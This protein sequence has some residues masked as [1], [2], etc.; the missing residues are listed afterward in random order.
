MESVAD[1]N[2]VGCPAQSDFFSLKKKSIFNDKYDVIKKVW[3]EKQMNTLFDLL[4]WYSLLDVRPF[5]EAVLIYLDLY[6]R[7][8]LDI[9]KMAISLPGISIHWAFDTMNKHETKFHLF[10]PKDADMAEIMR[11]NSNGEISQVFNHCQIKN[12]SCILGNLLIKVESFQDANALY[13]SATA[14]EMHMGAPRVYRFNEKINKLELG[15]LSGVSGIQMCWLI[16][17]EKGIPDL[18]NAEKNGEK[19]IGPRG[20]KV[21]GFSPSSNTVYEFDR[22]Y[23][24]GCLC[25]KQNKLKSLAEQIQFKKY[26]P[27]KRQIQLENLCMRVCQ[28]SCSN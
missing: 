1:L 6:K 13:L 15:H 22:Y 24:H 16:E 5:L 8:N 2:V 23:F 17:I 3:A 21:D 10:A 25:I 14:M 11:L 4:K 27:C 19:R 28:K 18:Q 26:M 20:L 12:E 9:F 7:R